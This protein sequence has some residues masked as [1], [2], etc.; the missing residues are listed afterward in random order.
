[1]QKSTFF[2]FAKSL[3]IAIEY[4][5]VALIELKFSSDVFKISSTYTNIGKARKQVYNTI[6]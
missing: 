6:L 5:V 1:M 4:F 3:G 2:L